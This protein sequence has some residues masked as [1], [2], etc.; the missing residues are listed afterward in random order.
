VIGG[1][2]QKLAETLLSLSPFQKAGKGERMA[3]VPSLGETSSKEM[4]ERRNR[5]VPFVR[6]PESVVRRMLDLAEVKPSETVYDLGCGDGGILAIAAREYGAR[7]VGIEVREDL[8]ERAR[9]R[10]RR[11]GIERQVHIVHG[12]FFDTDV[13]EADVVTLYLLSRVNAE[14]RPELQRQ[15]RKNARVVSYA[16]PVESWKPVQEKKGEAAYSSIFLYRKA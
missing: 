2:R 15:L 11:L 9:A 13:R 4:D 14:L 6:T 5:R 12:S 8:V 3:I 10:M 7:C 1:W 16:F